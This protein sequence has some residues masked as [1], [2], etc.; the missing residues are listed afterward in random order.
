MRLS[1]EGMW[2]LCRVENELVELTVERLR[3]LR[4]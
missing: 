4:H 3:S 1:I 2:N